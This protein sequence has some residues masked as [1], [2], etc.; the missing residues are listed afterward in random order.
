M[1]TSKTLLRKRLLWLIGIVGLVAIFLGITYLGW[2]QKAH[3][4]QTLMQVL[5]LLGTIA[6]FGYRK[7]WKDRDWLVVLILLAGIVVR[8]GYALYT[9]TTLRFHDLAPIDIRATGHAGYVLN[10]Y[11]NGTLPPTNDFQFAQPP[12]YYF[13]AAISMKIYEVTSGI[14]NSVELFEAVRLVSCIASIA[15]L[16]VSYRICRELKL[17]GK[18]TRIALAVCAFLPNHYLLAGRANPDGLAVFFCFC[19]VWFALR[20]Y[21][22][23]S[24]KNTVGLALCFGLGMMTKMT[25]AVLAFPVGAMMMLLFWKQCIR[26][27]NWRLVARLSL[28]LVIAVPLGLWHPIRNAILYHQ[29]MINVNE[30]TPADPQYIGNLSLISRYLLFDPAKLFSPLYI[31]WATGTNV[32]LYTVKSAVF[33]EFSYDI[34]PLVPQVLLVSN[35]LLIALS[36]YAT[37]RVAIQAFRTHDVNWGFLVCTG[38][39]VLLSYLLFTARY[40]FCC[41][42][43]YRYMV[44]TSLIGALVLAKY[45]ESRPVNSFGNKL[46]RGVVWLGVMLFSLASIAMYTNIA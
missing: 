40:P 26:Q 19:I 30:M 36:A 37:L 38:A 24:I 21:R 8:V 14:T 43:D 9:P 3:R 42:M 17:N 41:S 10:L 4:I 44:P 29:S 7:H 35:I 20:W 33:G 5:L 6:I 18:S 31:D 11:Q 12:F 16:L 32:I 25:V 27:G 28:F 15:A 45:S 39:I 1:N 2:Y 46:F 22:D 23:P 34:T 13:L